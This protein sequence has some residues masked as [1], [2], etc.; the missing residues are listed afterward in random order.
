MDFKITENVWYTQ[1]CPYYYVTPISKIN[2]LVQ[3][4]HP[5]LVK[6]IGYC[7]EDEQL[8]LLYEFMHKD[9]EVDDVQLNTSR[10]DLVLC[11]QQS[12]WLSLKMQVEFSLL[13]KACGVVG[14][15]VDARYAE[16]EKDKLRRVN[17]EACGV[18]ETMWTQDAELAWDKLEE[19]VYTVEKKA[20]DKH[21]EQVYALRNKCI[22]RK[23]KNMEITIKELWSRSHDCSMRHWDRTEEPFF[24]ELKSL[25]FFI[26]SCLGHRH[27]LRSC[28]TRKL[29]DFGLVKDCSKGE[30]SYVITRVMGTFGYAAPQYVSTDRDARRFSRKWD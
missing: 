13:H 16:M 15:H 1:H 26:R 5:N 9:V 20:R 19:Q 12:W 28:S 11:C 18:A 10:R 27:L 17:Q 29:S 30:T 22:S 6:L 23:G 4:S 24:L 14:Y 21:G 8:L 3:L 25:H 7:L 2:Y